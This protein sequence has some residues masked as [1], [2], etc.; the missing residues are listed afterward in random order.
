MPSEL[1]PELIQTTLQLPTEQR[2]ELARLLLDS[3]EG[4]QE[5]E[6]SEVPGSF[7]DSATGE[8]YGIKDLRAKLAESITAIE[9]GDYIDIQSEQELKSLFDSIKK[10]G[11]ERLAAKKS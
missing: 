5:R 11:R 1:T 9:S 6:T 8:A 2:G 10:Q 4:E 3:L 7:I